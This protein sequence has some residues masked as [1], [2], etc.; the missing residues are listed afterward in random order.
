MTK[1][2]WIIAVFGA[3]VLAVLTMWGPQREPGKNLNLPWQIELTSDGGSKVF[4]ITLGVGTLAE[5]ETTM[6]EA[7]KISLFKLGEKYVVE[8]FFEEVK[9]GGLRG[10]MVMIM[11]IPEVDMVQMYDRGL[12]SSGLPSGS[13]VTLTPEDGEKVKRSPVG[14][15]TYLPAAS[16]DAVAIKKRFGEPSEQLQEGKSDVVHYLYPRLGLDVAIQAGQRPI[17]QYVSPKE[18]FRLEQPL[19]LSQ[20][21]NQ[22]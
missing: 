4:G 11:Q 17:L 2:T 5:A 20:Q 16:I 7:A 21:K 19:R 14:A 9:H 22:K 10:K 13:K 8:G 12:R 6:G 3:A 15:I 1:K 18:F